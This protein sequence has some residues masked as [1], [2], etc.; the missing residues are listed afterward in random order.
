MQ[1]LH[2]ALWLS[3]VRVG[4]LEWMEAGGEQG[5]HRSGTGGKWAGQACCGQKQLA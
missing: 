4:N 3:Q 2:A 5:R 1:Q